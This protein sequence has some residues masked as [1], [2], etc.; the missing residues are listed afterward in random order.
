MSC[1]GCS[2]EHCVG[3]IVP[4]D[5]IGEGVQQCKRDKKLSFLASLLKVSVVSIGRGDR[6]T[7]SHEAH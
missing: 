2:F 7:M 3:E 4:P 5:F 6:G 1:T